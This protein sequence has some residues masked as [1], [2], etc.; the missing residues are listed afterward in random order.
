MSNE[1]EIHKEYKGVI[2][3]EQLVA[4]QI[5][6]I[7]Q[8]GTEKDNEK[9]EE[10]VEHLVDLLSPIHENKALEFKKE[11]SV[12]YDIDPT[13]KMRY[14]GLFRFIKR[15]LAEDNIVWKKS[16]YE[17]GTEQPKTSDTELE[18][19]EIISIEPV[20]SVESKTKELEEVED[21]FKK[22]DDL[23]KNK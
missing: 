5:D 6:R 20:E 16:R 13:G 4:R 12:S 18:P 2:G 7:N 21:E 14:R 1:F 11:H 22:I 23:F 9:Y 10:G 3:I 17:V 19:E 15:L 8:Y